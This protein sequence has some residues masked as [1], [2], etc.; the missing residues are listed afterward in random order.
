MGQRWPF[1]WGSLAWLCCREWHNTVQAN[2]AGMCEVRSPWMDHMGDAAAQTGVCF[3]SP[4]YSGSQ[5]LCKALFGKPLVLCTS[6]VQ[7]SQAY[8][9]GCA[10]ST[11]TQIG[12]VSCVPSWL[13]Q[14]G[15][16]GVLQWLSLRCALCLLRVTGLKLKDSWQ[17]W[18]IQGPRKTWLVTGSLGLRLQR[19]LALCLWLWY[20][21]LSAS[22]QREGHW[23]EAYSPWYS[24]GCNPLFCN[25]ARGHDEM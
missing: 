17:I 7:A 13:Q 21:F 19:P 9:P 3:P 5:V 22:R 12:S 25:C 16:L 10:T 15:F 4:H 6:Q 18:T 2:T 14:P 11:Q 8:I 20:T 1:Y 24:L 23:Q